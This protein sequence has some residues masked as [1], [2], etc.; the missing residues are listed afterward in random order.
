MQ[1]SDADFGEMYAPTVAVPSVRLVTVLICDQDFALRHPDIKQ[2]FGELPLG[3]RSLFDKKLV[4]QRSLYGL[5]QASIGR[6]SQVGGWMKSM[7]FEQCLPDPTRFQL[8]G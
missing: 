6:H 2:A 8:D 5:R 7:G 4:L 3:C 1:R